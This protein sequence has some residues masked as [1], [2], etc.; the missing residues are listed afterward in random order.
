[1]TPARKKRLTLI[2]LIFATFAAAVA[3]L[4][5]AMQNDLNHYYSLEQIA[6]HAAPL[7]QPGIRVGGMV[8][9]K[10]LQR[11]GDSL[12]VHFRITDYRH[13]PLDVRYTGILPDLFREKQGVIARG[14]LRADGEFQADEILA[15]H[16]EN[17]MP[18]ELKADLERSGYQHQSQQQP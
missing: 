4:L 8:E 16:D 2:S 6:V 1:M 11:E 15:K 5:Y 17:Y 10:S 7:D 18:P 12:T 14:T 13:P 9:E 3:L